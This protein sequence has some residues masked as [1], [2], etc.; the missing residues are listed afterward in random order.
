MRFAKAQAP[1]LK[2]GALPLQ[3]LPGLVLHDAS[4]ECLIVS[5]LEIQE[6]SARAGSHT[7]VHNLCP[8]GATK[9]SVV[10]LPI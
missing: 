5:P 9:G 3:G 2:A 7:I 1:F 4:A 10:G 8:L 6:I